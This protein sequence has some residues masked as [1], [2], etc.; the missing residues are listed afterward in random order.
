[1]KSEISH[2]KYLQLAGLLHL[3]KVHARNVEQCRGAAIAILAIGDGPAAENC[4]EEI[5]ADIYSPTDSDVDAVLKQL[6]VRVQ[7]TAEVG[8]A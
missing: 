2:N 6:D 1:M 5:D 3:A 8:N 7:S 4:K